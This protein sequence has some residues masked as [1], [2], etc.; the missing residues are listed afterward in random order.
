MRSHL[1]PLFIALLACASAAR[2]EDLHVGPGQVYARVEEA[3]A[4]AKAGDSVL[5][6][7]PAE[8]KAYSQVAVLVRKA[9]ITF[10]GV[11]KK[12]GER[13]ALSGEGF[14][15]SGD[16]AV[17]RAIFQFDPGASGCVVE[18]FEL[19]GAHNGSHN[20]AGVRINQANSVTIRDCEIHDNDMGIMSNGDASAT[21][22]AKRTGRGQLIESCAIHHNGS[23]K[24]PGQNHNLYLGGTSVTLRGCEVYSSLTGH[25]VKS[26]AHYTRVEYCYVHDSANREIDL[27]DDK[28]NTELEHS[29]AVLLGNIIV[30]DPKCAGNRAVIHFGQ[31]GGHEHNG[32]LYLV[33]NTILTPFVS[34]VV[35]VS[36]AG[37][38]VD[39]VN[40]L[41]C[42]PTG[43]QAKQVLAERFAKA[44][45][46][47]GRQ[48]VRGSNNF[49]SN[50]FHDA[51]WAKGLAKLAPAHFVPKFVEAAKGNYRPAERGEMEMGETIKNI[52]FAGA[53]GEMEAMGEMYEY[54]PPLAVRKIATP[55][56]PMCGAQQL[57]K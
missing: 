35:Q 51:T 3:L 2:A 13:V 17:S 47:N 29:D 14:D 33:Q 53:D 24:E 28:I 6:H 22:M 38:S 12:K 40:N 18:G 50:S 25:N 37:A 20:G 5:V 21:E 31:D 45:A 43:K 48:L 9:K 10:R 7:A 44:K 57:D 34:P 39:L 8:G 15:Y 55:A 27:V 32:T 54:K 41:I 49:M 30:K 56:R 42:D 1:F 11:G 19:T 52:R 36:A 26:R 4:K 46:E 23:T 16:G